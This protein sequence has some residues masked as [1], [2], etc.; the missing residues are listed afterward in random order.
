[1]DES[2]W[3]AIPRILQFET[4]YTRSMPESSDLAVGADIPMNSLTTMKDGQDKRRNEKYKESDYHGDEYERSRIA[5]GSET[6]FV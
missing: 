2:D 4:D 6:S 1:M 3:V 5:M